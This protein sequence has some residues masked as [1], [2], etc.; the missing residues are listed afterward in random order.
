MRGHG[1]AGVL[2]GRAGRNCV[3]CVAGIIF[4]HPIQT[5]MYLQICDGGSAL[6]I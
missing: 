1:G 2:G 4:C 3:D 5:I 6:K